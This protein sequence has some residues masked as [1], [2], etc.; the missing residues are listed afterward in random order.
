MT[1]S[2]TIVV[3]CFFAEDSQAKGCHVNILSQ[4][5]NTMCSMTIDKGSEP[6]ANGRFELPNGNYEI[7]VYDIEID[8]SL[9]ENPAYQHDE[10]VIILGS[11]VSGL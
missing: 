8:G 2:D 9:S 1:T 6:Q 3:T 5:G 7:L 4:E 10:I 11:S